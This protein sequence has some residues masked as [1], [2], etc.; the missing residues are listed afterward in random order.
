VKASGSG[1]EDNV[2]SNTSKNMRAEP[3]QLWEFPLDGG[4]LLGWLVA[5]SK[6]V[7]CVKTGVKTGVET[8]AET[9][10]ETGAEPRWL[11][12]PVDSEPELGPG[13]RAVPLVS[14]SGVA[15]RVALRWAGA[16][17]VR[18]AD[19]WFAVPRLILARAFESRLADDFGHDVGDGSSETKTKSDS[20]SRQSQGGMFASDRADSG[21]SDR[22]QVARE[23]ANRDGAKHGFGASGDLGDERTSYR[24][25]GASQTSEV[26]EAIRVSDANRS[27]ES[28]DDPGVWQQAARDL[29]RWLARRAVTAELHSIE[30][31]DGRKA[32]GAGNVDGTL[33]G[34]DVSQLDRDGAGNA[35]EEADLTSP[36]ERPL[37]AASHDWLGDL[38]AEQPAQPARRFAIEA[39]PDFGALELEC[40]AQGFCLRGAERPSRL[41]CLGANG[42]RRFVSWMPQ[43]AGGWR[44]AWIERS[45]D[46]VRLLIEQRADLWDVRFELPS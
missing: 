43:L 20:A 45:S 23:R 24:A 44:S 4:G 31:S 9:G 13:D 41:V 39:G 19:L 2:P 26:F 15:E 42:G 36:F 38:V 10:V 14:E 30:D 6:V 1:L 40:D 25:H 46:K 37:A 8:R 5:D 28:T 11:M 29:D 32:S 7:P 17:W 35:F 3:G 18:E 33:A 21:A 16:R 12:V 34:D 22:D 27:S